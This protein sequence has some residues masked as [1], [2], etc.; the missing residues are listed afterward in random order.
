MSHSGLQ[1]A[2]FAAEG[3][4]IAAVQAMTWGHLAP[5]TKQKYNGW[6]LFINAAYGGAIEIVDAEFKELPDS[7][8]L[9][10]DMMDFA[11]KHIEQFYNTE[12]KSDGIYVFEGWYMKHKN[13]NYRFS[14][15]TRKINPVSLLSPKGKKK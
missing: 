15:K 3:E 12:E 1:E 9:Y 10:E 8:S 7:P 5:L 4:Y 14:G 6:I 2:A 13:G 11:A